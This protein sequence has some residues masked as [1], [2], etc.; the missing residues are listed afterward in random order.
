MKGKK[1]MGAGKQ[2]FSPHGRKFSKYFATSGLRCLFSIL[3]SCLS[4][5]AS[6]SRKIIPRRVAGWSR[7]NGRKQKSRDSVANLRQDSERCGKGLLPSGGRGTSLRVRRQICLVRVRIVPAYGRFTLSRY[8]V[9]S[10]SPR[11]IP[12]IPFFLLLA[13]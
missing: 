3:D 11:R 9:P 12:A 6:L 13:I 1:S 10:S 2:L 5:A 4:R 7:N 8:S